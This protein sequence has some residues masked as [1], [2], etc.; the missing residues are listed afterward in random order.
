M[1]RPLLI[2]A[3]VFPMLAACATWSASAKESSPAQTAA[4]KAVCTKVMGLTHSPEESAGCVETLSDELSRENAYARD[5]S[6]DRDCVQQGVERSTPEFGRCVLDHR[7]SAKQ[8]GSV[9]A[10]DASSITTPEGFSGGY[11]SSSFP[12]RYRR[13]E[14]ACAAIGL[15]P[16]SGPFESCARDL[17]NNMWLIEHPPG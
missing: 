13:G 3:A 8:T 15:Q 11:F 16:A 5:A 1:L 6:A 17:D 7:E 4:L 10:I 14:Y 9:T 12:M 2:A